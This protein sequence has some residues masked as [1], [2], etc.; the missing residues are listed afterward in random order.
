MRNLICVCLLSVLALGACGGSDPDDDIQFG[1]GA[2]SPGGG[3]SAPAANAT[4]KGK[5]SF[6]GTPPMPKKV[7]TTGDPKCVNPDLRAEDMIVSDGG[8]ENVMIYV[9]SPVQGGFPTPTTEVLVDQMGCHYIP[10]AFTAMVNQPIKFR[11]S[12]N[13][14]HNIHAHAEVNEPFNISQAV[15]GLEDIKRFS[16][17]EIMLPIRCD[18]HNW[19]NAFVGVFTHP[20]HTVSKTGGAYELKLAPGKYEITAHHEKLGKKTMMVEVMENGTADLNFSFAATDK[21]AD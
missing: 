7:S 5:I 3:G 14:S 18:V 13:T 10:H 9:S 11:N 19:M 2:A 6:E 16:K 12:D 4:V 20:Y 8:L 1:G 17:A 15:K 21:A